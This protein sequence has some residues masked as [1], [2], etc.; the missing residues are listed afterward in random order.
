MHRVVTDITVGGIQR[1]AIECVEM[2]ADLPGE[3][4]QETV[5][6]IAQ[7]GLRDGTSVSGFLHQCTI[8]GNA[9]ITGLFHMQFFQ[10]AVDASIWAPRGQHHIHTARA[11]RGNGRFDRR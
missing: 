7:R 3:L 9:I 2:R 1:I 6:I 11:R 8:V 5:I 10:I 4:L